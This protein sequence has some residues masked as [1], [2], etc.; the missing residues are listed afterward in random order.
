MNRF[1]LWFARRFEPREG[2]LLFGLVISILSVA[3]QAVSTAE[4][5]PE[6]GVVWLSFFVAVVIAYTFIVGASSPTWLQWGIIFAYLLV[7]TTLFLMRFQPLLWLTAGWEV[8]Q[9]ET[10]RSGTIFLARVNGW[11]TALATGT[12]SDETL[13]FAFGLSI[14][15]GVMVAFFMF[16]TYR[17]RRPLV[18]V[19]TLLLLSGLNAV[20]S[21][22]GEVALLLLVVLCI[23]YLTF[24]QQYLRQEN[25]DEQQIDYS[26]EMNVSTLLTAVF[27]TGALLFAGLVLPSLPYSSV[28][29]WFQQT[30]MVQ[31]FERSFEQYFSGVNTA[32]AGGGFGGPISGQVGEGGIGG[33]PSPTSGVLPR[34]YLLGSPPELAK[35]PVFSATLSADK[36][37]SGSLHWRSG[38]Y[39]VYT[40]RGWRQS[41]PADTIL[42]TEQVADLQL[43]VAFDDQNPLHLQ[44]D[45]QVTWLAEERYFNLVTIGQPLVFDQSVSAFFW[46]DGDLSHVSRIAGTYEPSYQGTSVVVEHN[47]AILNQVEYSPNDPLYQ[48]YIALPD[49]VPERVI[50]LAEQIA[51]DASTPYEQ[52]LFIEQYLRQYPYNLDIPPLPLDVDPVDYFLFDLQ[53]GYCDL[54]ASS[55]VVMARSLGLPARLGVGYLNGESNDSGQVLITQDRGHSWAEIYFPE[56]GW[57]EFEPT[58]AFP[59]QTPTNL[60]E[61]VENELDPLLSEDLPSIPTGL[62]FAFRDLFGWVSGV[63]A[64]IL[65]VL[66][67]FWWQAYHWRREP[68]DMGELFHWLQDGALQLGYPL[69]A[70]E[71]ATEFTHG[72]LH[73]LQKGPFDSHRQTYS[74]LFSSII[75][76]LVS[77]YEV[78]QYSFS[79]VEPG[80]FKRSVQDWQR[81]RQPLMH[82]WRRRRW[83]RFLAWWK[84]G[85]KVKHRTSY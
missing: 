47:R 76:A 66:A 27:V 39:D 51:A 13:I 61:Q 85:T 52:A 46:R 7:F 3:V 28:A 42:L 75:P 73:F 35:S 55:M 24:W 14:L 82:L 18:A 58:A 57:V 69:Q 59:V 68:K 9:A 84:R 63:A 19:S 2:W 48:H 45:Q 77:V 40:G 81:I 17:R 70:S 62:R 78:D 74:H 64:A 38:S 20:Y 56:V 72:F 54:Y 31:A 79:G 25:W 10:F 34:S 71:T 4:W 5:V 32:R 36:P 49:S 1:I 37:L 83:Q 44:L 12:Q 23:L 65:I 33:V 16:T 53:E 67:I 22:Q 30:A 29:R 50:A 8:Y 43:A 15:A 60:D 80:V 11:R 41:A 26:A 21:G 6:S